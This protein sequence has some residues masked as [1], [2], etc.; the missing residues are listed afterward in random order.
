MVRTVL[1]RAETSDGVPLSTGALLYHGLH[2]LDDISGSLH[3]LPES[4]GAVGAYDLL[5]SL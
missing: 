1:K 5:N 3:D 4:R 2:V